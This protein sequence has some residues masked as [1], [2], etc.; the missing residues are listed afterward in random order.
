MQ[1]LK[2]VMSWL[3]VIITSGAMIG[4]VILA[5]LQPYLVVEFWL[6]L[7]VMIFFLIGINAIPKLKEFMFNHQRLVIFILAI[8]L[9]MPDIIVTPDFSYN[10]FRTILK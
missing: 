8:L 4:N 10:P 9:V 6:M 5:F 3:L 2:F 1:R 7:V